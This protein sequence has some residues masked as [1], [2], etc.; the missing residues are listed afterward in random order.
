MFRTFARLGVVAADLLLAGVPAGPAGASGP[1]LGCRVGSA[2]SPQL[3]RTCANSA[4]ASSYGVLFGVSGLSGPATFAWSFTGDVVAV[5]GGCTAT[6]DYCTVSTYGSNRESAL[7]ASVTVTQAGQATT[8]TS[9]A[10]VWRYCGS[11]PCS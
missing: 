6:S 3:T 5:T 2:P 1:A 9:D 8:L 4:P 10:Y 7:V 11:Y